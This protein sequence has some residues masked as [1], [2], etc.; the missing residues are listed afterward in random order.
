VALGEE[1][2]S[3]T[4]PEYNFGRQ[5]YYSGHLVGNMGAFLLILSLF[6]SFVFGLPARRPLSDR[7][8][9]A[10]YDYVVVGCGVSGLVVSMRLSQNPDVSVLCI[11]AGPL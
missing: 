2:A 5:A 4:G 11:E 3:P 10:T 9:S 1:G 8:A 6:V 7:S